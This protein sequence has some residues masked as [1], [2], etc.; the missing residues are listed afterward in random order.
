[1]PRVTRAYTGRTRAL[2][3][4]ETARRAVVPVL[5]DERATRR[6]KR[7]FRRDLSLRL[8]FLF[9]CR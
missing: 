7:A 6:S 8:F 2:V 1:M 4:D 3:A 9:Y 5:L